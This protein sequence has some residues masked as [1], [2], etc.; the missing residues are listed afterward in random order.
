VAVDVVATNLVGEADDLSNLLGPVPAPPSS[1]PKLSSSQATSA[2]TPAPAAVTPSVSQMQSSLDGISRPSGKKAVTA[3]EKTDVFKTV[4]TAPSGG[5]LSVVWT[6][7]VNIGKGKHKKTKTVIVASGSE[8]TASAST[9]G[10]VIRLT[11]A[12]RALLKKTPSGLLLT[13]TEKF[14]TVGGIAKTVIKKF[15]V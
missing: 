9:V 8:Q 15:R 7:K 14:T 5:T 3:L 4:F 2:D 13:D 11:A 10:V 6:T 1:T 12:G